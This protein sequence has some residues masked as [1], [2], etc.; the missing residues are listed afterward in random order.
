MKACIKY[1]LFIHIFLLL[2]GLAGKA[3]AA[4]ITE[5]DKRSLKKYFILHKELYLLKL[6]KLYHK[7]SKECNK[8]SFDMKATRI[9]PQTIVIKFNPPSLK[10][11]PSLGKNTIIELEPTS[12]SSVSFGIE[13]PPPHLELPSKGGQY[14]LDGYYYNGYRKDIHYLKL[15]F[16]GKVYEVNRKKECRTQGGKTTCVFVLKKKLL[17]KGSLVPY[18][19]K[20]QIPLKLSEKFHISKKQSS[21]DFVVLV[22][23][24]TIKPGKA[25]LIAEISYPA[26]NP[27][28]LGECDSPAACKA[29]SQKNLVKKKNKKSSARYHAIR[30]V[31]LK[32]ARDNLLQEAFFRC[33]PDDPNCFGHW[34]RAYIYNDQGR[35]LKKSDIEVYPVVDYGDNKKRLIYY[36]LKKGAI[37][38]F[39][40]KNTGYKIETF[41][42]DHLGGADDTFYVN[43]TP[44]GEGAVAEIEINSKSREFTPI[45]VKSSAPRFEFRYGVVGRYYTSHPVTNDMRV[46]KKSMKASVPLFSPFR[47]EVRGQGVFFGKNYEIRCNAHKGLEAITKVAHLKPEGDGYKGVCEFNLSKETI[48]LVQKEENLP[49]LKAD[50]GIYWHGKLFVKREFDISLSDPDSETI[51]SLQTVFKSLK[52]VSQGKERTFPRVD[53]FFSP[54]GELSTN[55][56]VYGKFHFKNGA[57]RV[58]RATLKNRIKILDNNFISSSVGN[59]LKIK[60][61]VSTKKKIPLY[62]VYL[63]PD[64]KKVKSRPGYIYPNRAYLVQGGENI[65]TLVVEGKSNLKKY[66]IK[67]VYSVNHGFY[68]ATTRFDREGGKWQSTIVLPKGTGYVMAIVLS[69]SGES[70]F[71]LR[72][73]GAGFYRAYFVGGIKGPSILKTGNKYTVW[74]K[75]KA[76]LPEDKLKTLKCIWSIKGEGAGIVSLGKPKIASDGNGI[77]KAQVYVEKGKAR[78]MDID[79]KLIGD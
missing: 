53:V 23:D 74:A 64:G 10:T 36:Y 17:Y 52:T 19:I 69:P 21:N 67:W 48:K 3:Y 14:Y 46:L 26:L 9:E 41:L 1:L 12:A 4:T 11:L 59:C 28:A 63:S 72:K 66:S 33:K 51:T 61:T 24:K 40:K 39:T 71:T 32:S 38:I 56:C 34:S 30:V 65:Y 16:T 5:D 25:T 79:V 47:V 43:L 50:V 55:V 6:K 77:C 27:D 58:V 15:F 54:H 2:C 22:P 18:L 78:L 20:N 7:C 44:R 29:M 57:Q 62:V 13:S 37:T 31:G 8:L 73:S 76:D 60:S 70:V 35:Q 75:F 42:D 68:S 49:S 45:V